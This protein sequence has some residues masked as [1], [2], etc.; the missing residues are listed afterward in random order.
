[1]RDG[2]NG[3][4]LKSGNTKN[5]GAKKK[6]PAIDVILADIFHDEEQVNRIIASLIDQAVNSGN[7]RAAEV[8]LDRLYGKASQKIESTINIKGKPSWMDED[9]SEQKS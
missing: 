2:R 9:G 1:M 8:L 5:V 6:I 7:V 4:K 3:G